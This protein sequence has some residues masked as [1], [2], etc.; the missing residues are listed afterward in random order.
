MFASSVLSSN[1]SPSRDFDI[2]CVSREDITWPFVPWRLSYTFRQWCSDLLH[3]WLHWMRQPLS[4]LRSQHVNAACLDSKY[5]A[6]S[7]LFSDN[8]YMAAQHRTFHNDQWFFAD[9]YT[10]SREYSMLFFRGAGPLTRV[11]PMSDAKDGNKI[12]YF[13]PDQLLFSTCFNRAT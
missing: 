3:H 9:V 2:P 8:I 7:H 10:E 4:T 13:T 1:M 12:S 6:I 5:I 11:R